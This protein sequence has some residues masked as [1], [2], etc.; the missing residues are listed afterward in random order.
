M[1]KLRRPVQLVGQISELV[2]IPCA[3]LRLEGMLEVPEHAATVVLFAHG[4]GSGRLSPRNNSVARA[5]R[6][7][8]LGTLLIDLLSREED[9]VYENRFNIEL[10]TDRLAAA[11]SWLA[12]HSTTRFMT[13]GLFGASTGAA[14]ALNLAAKLPED[15][16]AV[17][18][19][20]GRPDLSGRQNLSKVRVPTLL[21]VGGADTEVLALNKAA[22]RELRCRKE[23][24]VVPGATHLFE[25]PGTLERV[26]E[27]AANWFV[28]EIGAE[29]QSGRDSS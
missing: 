1:S 7:A 12:E 4:S 20:G 9:E 11:V 19:R 26:A 25:E 28:R 5:L 16:A 14:A 18:S 15:I 10:L 29:M 22:Y 23:L 21:I 27:L 2:Q 8:G 24:A 17:V 13:V 6:D 3:G